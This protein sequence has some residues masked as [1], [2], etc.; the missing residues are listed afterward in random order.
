MEQTKELESLLAAF[1]LTWDNFPGMA[2]LIDE[3]HTLLAVN[4][5]AKEFGFEEGLCC[6]QVGNP[7]IHRNCKKGKVTLQ[8]QA[9]VDRVVVDKIR[10]WVPV[11]GYPGIV[12]HFTVG[13]P[14]LELE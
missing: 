8:E 13:I 4:A 6:A 3:R 10:G 11:D 14:E 1:H 9:I 5:K 7:E 2:R 12:V